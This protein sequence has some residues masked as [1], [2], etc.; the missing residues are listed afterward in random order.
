MHLFVSG[1]ETVDKADGI[2][3]CVISS[4]CVWNSIYDQFYCNLLSCIKSYPIC[5]NGEWAIRLR[6]MDSEILGFLEFLYQ[7]TFNFE[8]IRHYLCQGESDFPCCQQ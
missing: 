2:K 3:C 1:R 7:T 6:E 5:Y 8:D 4:S